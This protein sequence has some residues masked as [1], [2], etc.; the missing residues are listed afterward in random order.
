M[1]LRYAQSFLAQIAQT[2]ACSRIHPLPERCARWLLLVHDRVGA[3]HFQLTQEF[4]ANMLGVRRPSV[5]VVARTLQEAGLITYHRGTITVL[6]RDGLEAG[7]CECY[8]RIQQTTTALL[9]PPR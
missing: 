3:D 6:D 5:T 2:S 4:L 8:A 1:L 9:G 7:A